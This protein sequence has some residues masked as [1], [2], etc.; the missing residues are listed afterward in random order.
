MSYYSLIIITLLE[1]EE[2]EKLI[3]TWVENSI[4]IE[5]KLIE[6]RKKEA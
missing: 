5:K 6:K 1:E 2:R 3:I 4:K